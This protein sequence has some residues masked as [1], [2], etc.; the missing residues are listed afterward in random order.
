MTTNSIHGHLHYEY[1]KDEDL[2]FTPDGND[3]RISGNGNVEKV[4]RT[5][6]PVEDAL[7]ARK[8]I[9]IND[10]H[11]EASEAAKRALMQEAKI[12]H[13]ARHGHVVKL[14]MTYFYECEEEA[15][16]A[17][18]MERADGNLDAYLKGRV[19]HK[20]RDQLAEWFGCLTGVV[21]YVHGFGIRHR[22]IKP[23]NIL[24]KDMRIL[25]A[26]FGISKMGFGITMPTTIPALARSRTVDYCATEVEDGST[27]GRSADIFSLGAVFLEML[28]AYACF[29]ERGNL[30]KILTSKGYRSYA[31]AVVLVH[32]FMDK[33]EQEF[34]SDE[35]FLKVLSCCRKMLHAERDQRPLA[36]DIN[37]VWLT[38]QPSDRPLVSCTCPEVVYTSDENVLV[39]L[40]KADSLEQVETY[41][42]NGHDPNT[43]GAIH[44][45]STHGHR[46]IVQS[47]LEHK[48]DVNLRDYSRQTALHCAAGYGHKDIVGMLL[49]RGADTRL[50]DEEGQTALHC[51]AG[52]GHQ[53]VV[54][55]LLSKGAD[56]Q[57][58]DLEGR[59]ALHFAA[60]RGCHDVV[61]T[62]LN[63]G[64]NSEV[65]DSR[66]RTAL[67]FAAGCGSEKV[68]EMLLKVINKDVVSVQDENGQMA[69][70]FAARGKQAGGKYEAVR[71][72]LQEKAGNLP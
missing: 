17:I 32:Q 29:Q 72:M 65:M 55:L 13:R 43:L 48:V 6:G 38:L 49:E 21:A 23:S 39:E 47:F 64:A 7:Y 45:A 60:R 10:R 71:K 40:C 57:A 34:Q 8:N 35:W 16:F 63:E 14:V 33:L 50:K 41:L 46:R 20:K 1:T 3:A 25:L 62:L 31:K 59:T 69:L 2:P 68:V 52:H 30:D 28:I 54:E 5:T 36:D 19:A 12:L 67:H 56:I 15:R 53:N 37:S 18:V 42:A 61:R 4:K 44:Q 11:S 26:D 51:A 24:I 9:T 70:H 27:R 22:D 66:G 58:T